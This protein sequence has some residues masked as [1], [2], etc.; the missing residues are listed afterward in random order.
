MSVLEVCSKLRKPGLQLSELCTLINTLGDCLLFEILDGNQ[1]VAQI[2]SGWEQLIEILIQTNHPTVRHIAF[3]NVKYIL[4]GKNWISENKH[5]L[6]EICTGVIKLL[7][8][9]NENI[10]LEI[11]DII[12]QDEFPIGKNKLP[13]TQPSILSSLI[14]SDIEI[15]NYLLSLMVQYNNCQFYFVVL[16]M[17]NSFKFAIKDIQT[18]EA[19]KSIVDQLCQLE[20]NLSL[21]EINRETTINDENLQ[22]IKMN[23]EY[24][25]QEFLVIIFEIFN[26]I[27]NKFQDVKVVCYNMIKDELNLLLSEDLLGTI[28]YCPYYNLIESGFKAMTRTSLYHPL[29][30]LDHMKW[31]RGIWNLITFKIFGNSSSKYPKEEYES[32]LFKILSQAMKSILTFYL[33]VGQ[34]L[35]IWDFELKENNINIEVDNKIV[36]DETIFIFN[37]NQIVQE[38]IEF[39][40]NLP[41]EYFCSNDG[42]CEYIS[43]LS[44][45]INIGL[46]LDHGKILGTH[47]FYY[48][49]SFINLVLSIA[50]FLQGIKELEIFQPFQ[51]ENTKLLE[52]YFILNFILCKSYYLLNIVGNYHQLEIKD[53]SLIRELSSNFIEWIISQSNLHMDKFLI[54]FSEQTIKTLYFDLIPRWITQKNKYR[55]IGLSHNSN[56]EIMFLTLLRNLYK[57]AF[58]DGQNDLPINETLNQEEIA[59]LLSNFYF[60]CLYFHRLDSMAR[61]ETLKD[62]IELQE[63][64]EEMILSFLPCLRITNAYKYAKYFAVIRRYKISRAIFES[65]KLYTLESRAWIH[66][67]VYITQFYDC[68]MSFLR[69]NEASEYQSNS[70]LQLTLQKDLVIQLRYIIRNIESDFKFINNSNICF[71]SSIY[72]L[73]IHKINEFLSKSFNSRFN[74]ESDNQQIDHFVTLSYLVDILKTLFGLANIAKPI[75]TH[76]YQIITQIYWSFKKITLKVLISYMKFAMESFSEIEDN[77]NNQKSINKSSDLLKQTLLLALGQKIP[78]FNILVEKSFIDNAFNIFKLIE[79]NTFPQVKWQFVRRNVSSENLANIFLLNLR[80]HPNDLLTSLSKNPRKPGEKSSFSLV[81]LRNSVLNNDNPSSSSSSENHSKFPENA[82]SIDLESR[83]WQN[84]RPDTILHACM[85]LLAHVG[86]FPP[87]LLVQKTLPHIYL[88]GEILGLQNNK[89]C[90]TPSGTSSETTNVGNDHQ[91]V[92]VLKLFG[93]FKSGFQ[94]NLSEECYWV[95]IK[96]SYLFK[97]GEE[98]PASHILDLSITEAHFSWA[99]PIVRIPNAQKLKII[100]VPLNRYKICIG[101]P[102]TTF[103]NIL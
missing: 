11:L 79:F 31:M 72:F 66:I 25:N 50:H 89:D 57:Y 45:I 101:I 84:V 96:L 30:S 88:R 63:C 65:I 52:S 43:I 81:Y 10:Q 85:H 38:F 69:T 19:V 55:R 62:K 35:F 99:Q 26:N 80:K 7:Y 102:Y 58:L 67:L 97:E 92:P 22:Y 17:L 42:V 44:S 103:I 91:V 71:F 82:Y 33:E 37:L 60:C 90:V 48:D 70:S 46:E 87:I 61:K 49:R 3:Q 21:D 14:N 83:L 94:K 34:V 64:D 40:S 20:K 15:L 2:K 56:P 54:F 8:H 53:Q 41:K 24:S 95:R 28:N 93:F 39:I 5:A 4:N 98:L 75:S 27:P 73:A 6:S 23:C 18:K 12:L 86:R 74:D 29:V 16:K 100:S 32:I 36:K 51:E 47:K 76:T 1:N 77:P 78:K 9:W 68:I 13:L 59:K